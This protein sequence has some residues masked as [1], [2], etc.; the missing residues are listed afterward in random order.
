MKSWKMPKLG[1][2][3]EGKLALDRFLS[4]E[5]KKG[6]LPA[7]FIQSFR[8]QHTTRCVCGLGAF[9]VLLVGLSAFHIG[10]VYDTS[11]NGQ[12]VG[13]VT[14]TSE[15]Q[16]A[17]TAAETY[18]SDVLSEHYTFT[19]SVTTSASIAR[20]DDC[21]SSDDLT[22]AITEQIDEIENLAVLS[23]DGVEVC[24]LENAEDVQNVLDEI[25]NSYQ[26]K[27][28][29]QSGA[30]AS[31]QQNVTIRYKDTSANRSMSA[32]D[33]RHLLT[34]GDCVS[35]YTVPEN[36]TTDQVL[37][38]T[39]ATLEALT[40]LNPTVDFET[41]TED[42]DASADPET[43]TAENAIDTTAAA[44]NTTAT[45]S[46]QNTTAA[47]GQ[48]TEDNGKTKLT[49]SMVLS[50]PN[51]SSSI[52]T[53]QTTDV[54]H[55][56]EEIPYETVTK[57]NDQLPVGTQNI[58]QIG[59]AGSR[60]ITEQVVYVNGIRQSSTELENTV[61]KEPVQEII[62]VGTKP[63]L[64]AD[65]AASYAYNGTSTIT[66]TGTMIRPFAAGR[67][68]SNYGYRGSEFHTGVDFA[69]AAG[70]NVVAADSG[71]VIWAGPKGNYGN[72][73]MISH[74][75]GLVT[76]YAHNSEL[77]VSAG[78]AVSQGTVIAKVGS[79]GRSTGPHCHFEVRLYGQIQNPWSYIQ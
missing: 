15:L 54:E 58:V 20:T 9:A 40:Y 19:K 13:Y 17:M 52:L 32:E 43:Q 75:N 6:N 8:T 24:G 55:R 38:D 49:G 45:A 51:L 42:A 47:E 29:E 62:E 12:S 70:S 56:T 34:P 41:Q 36:A 57:E 16:Q 64:T 39:G 30:Q 46:A 27:L 31:F 74:G 3:T 65:S 61:S 26:S 60:D 2:L 21:L 53:V 69:G 33:L 23:I 18:A 78:D 71:T 22:S 66:G 14:T 76:L 59:V 79:T 35:T 50:V 67:V 25:K 7:R 5:A 44:A 10:F 63:V 72:C 68:T 73:V 11:I 28:P 4:S 1:F 48:E 77:E 37:S